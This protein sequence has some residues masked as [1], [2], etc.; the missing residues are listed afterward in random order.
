MSAEMDTDDDGSNSYSPS[1]IDTNPIDITPDR[2]FKKLYSCPVRDGHLASLLQCTAPVQSRTRDALITDGLRGL[3]LYFALWRTTKDTLATAKMAYSIANMAMSNAGRRMPESER[4]MNLILYEAVSE[5]KD[6][7]FGILADEW[8]QYII[9]NTESPRT[10]TD[11][12]F[13]EFA[14]VFLATQIYFEEDLH[15]SIPYVD[16]GCRDY[17]CPTRYICG[18]AG[19]PAVF[20]RLLDLSE[21][22]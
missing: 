11:K 7:A 14:F 21:R 19:G 1:P 3:D 12:F 18:S 4:E 20:R 13:T 6:A 9:Y 5:V 17:L 16:T 15:G 22:I 2:E 10:E 8:F